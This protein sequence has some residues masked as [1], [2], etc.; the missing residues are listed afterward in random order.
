MYNIINIVLLYYFIIYNDTEIFRLI[1]S[2]QLFISQPY[3]HCSTISIDSKLNNNKS[4][5]LW[6]KYINNINI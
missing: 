4:I 5:L 2:Y 3:S 1:L 6:Y